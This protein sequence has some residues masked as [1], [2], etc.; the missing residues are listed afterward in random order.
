M[1]L[2]HAVVIAGGSPRR[3]GGRHGRGLQGPASRIYPLGTRPPCD[4]E[5]VE[6]LGARLRRG[7]VRA[8]AAADPA[9][10]AALARV[11]RA[12]P[13]A[14]CPLPPAAALCACR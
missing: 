12:A 11:S 9:A 4:A 3:R 7:G 8:D 10:A 14:G 13:A 5:E 2:T 6:L 1:A